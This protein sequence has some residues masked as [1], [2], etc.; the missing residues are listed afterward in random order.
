M[1]AH[2]PGAGR[3][4]G[5]TA[6]VPGVWTQQPGNGAPVP[7]STDWGWKVPARSAQRP[8][9]STGPASEGRAPPA[10]LRDTATRTGGRREGASSPLS[11]LRA[12]ASRSSLQRAASSAPLAQARLPPIQP[13]TSPQSQRGPSQPR[14]G[15]AYPPPLLPNSGLRVRPGLRL[16]STWNV[17]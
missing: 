8:S 4:P 11:L 5:P 1:A 16:D 15:R 14:P 3:P 17:L 9:H 6:G 10:G 7:V 12:G 13:R 2:R